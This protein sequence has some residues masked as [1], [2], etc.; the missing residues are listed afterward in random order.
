MLNHEAARARIRV[1]GDAFIGEREVVTFHP[2]AESVAPVRV[3]AGEGRGKKKGRIRCLK[4]DACGK[5]IGVIF[6]DGDECPVGC[7]DERLRKL[8]EKARDQNLSVQVELDANHRVK[9]ITICRP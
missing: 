8:L 7:D 1:A 9:T 3:V 6:D 4:F 2:S 5:L